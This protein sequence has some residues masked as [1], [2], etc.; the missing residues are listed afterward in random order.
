MQVDVRIRLNELLDVFFQHDV[1]GC[2][3]EQVRGGSYSV[4]FN[5]NENTSVLTKP[6]NRITSIQLEI[7]GQRILSVGFRRLVTHRRYLTLEC[8][9]IEQKERILS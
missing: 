9:L 6:D 3:A 4:R 7:P 8:V 1:Y 5:R 2:E